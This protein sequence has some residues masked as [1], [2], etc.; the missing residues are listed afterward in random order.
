MV[1]VGRAS[2]VGL[3]REM[4]A[5]SEDAASNPPSSIRSAH[6]KPRHMKIF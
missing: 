6:R 2:L 1:T 5:I 3:S 4:V